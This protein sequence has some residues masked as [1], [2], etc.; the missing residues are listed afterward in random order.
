MIIQNDW[1]DF[2]YMHYNTSTL[3]LLN[4]SKVDTFSYFKKKIR[5]LIQGMLFSFM[6]E[7]LNL[8]QPAYNI[9]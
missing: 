2:R 6:Y 9:K 1:R 7:H 8:H 3:S 5:C 4:D